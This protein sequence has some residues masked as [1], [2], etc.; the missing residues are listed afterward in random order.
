MIF[1]AAGE[2]HVAYSGAFSFDCGYP[3]AESFICN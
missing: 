3:Q 2:L 1:S